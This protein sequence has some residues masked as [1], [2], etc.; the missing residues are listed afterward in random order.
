MSSS[1]SSRRQWPLAA[2]SRGGGESERLVAALARCALLSGIP[3]EQLEE[4]AAVCAT[5]TI[6][7]QEH[8]FAEGDPCGGLWVIAAGR[9]RLYHSDSQGRQQVVSFRGPSDLLEL[10]PALDGRAY[11]ASA[12]TL[13]ECDLVYVSR[14]TLASLGQRFPVTIRNTLEQLCTEV[15]QRDIATAIASLR[16]A[17]GRV[18]CTL[19]EMANQYGVRTEGGGVGIDFRLTRQDI[20]DRSGVTLETSIRVLSDL[21]R[22]ELVR[23]RA[24]S[25]EIVAI[26]GLRSLG[27]CGE[28]ELD[29]S[30]FAKQRP[31]VPV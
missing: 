1:S 15:R 8:V 21:Q 23:T 12:L 5:A 7:A 14:A 29:C 31:R 30:V 17:R 24:Q 6:A 25:I 11:S 20:A 22:R 19:V 2:A 10:A 26:E 16:D 9:V 28:C 13:E 27:E 18:I 3:V 4:V